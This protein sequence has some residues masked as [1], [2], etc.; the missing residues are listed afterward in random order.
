LSQLPSTPP[1]R[2]QPESERAPMTPPDAFRQVPTTPPD[3]FLVRAPPLATAFRPAQRDLHALA[4]PSTPALSSASAVEFISA[5]PPTPALTAMPG[6]PTLTDDWTPAYSPTSPGF[7]DVPNS[8]AFTNYSP[9]TDDSPA[10]LPTRDWR[11]HRYRYS[12]VAGSRSSARTMFA[13]MASRSRTRSRQRMGSSPSG[14]RTPRAVGRSQASPTRSS[15]RELPSPPLGTPTSPIATSEDVGPASRSPSRTPRLRRRILR[16][17]PQ[18]LP[19]RLRRWR[20][21][22]D[23]NFPAFIPS[24]T[25]WPEMETRAADITSPIVRFSEDNLQALDIEALGGSL[26]PVRAGAAIETPSPSRERPASARVAAAEVAPPMAPLTLRRVAGPSGARRRHQHIQVIVK[27]QQGTEAPF[28]LKRSKPLATFMGRYCTRFCILSSQV[29][30]SLRG[31]RIYPSDTP[32]MKGLE[33]LDCIDV[34]IVQPTQEVVLAPG[35]CVICLD[36]PASRAVVPCGHQC[37]CSNCPRIAM[38]R[39]PICRSHVQQIIQIYATGT[40]RSED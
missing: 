25:Y 34:E 28:K 23:M 35:D 10:Y 22:E 17:G 18:L 29:R 39:C 31:D 2:G 16:A 19:R 5:A 6:T 21:G 15:I 33:D 9:A 20:G 32:E 14:S 36:A 37:F 24:P 11:R 26:D 1:N 30:F 7:S 4:S 3:A 40:R 13:V 38:D 27:D 8:P 12:P